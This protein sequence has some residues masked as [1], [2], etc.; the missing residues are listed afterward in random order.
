MFSVKQVATKKG[1]LQYRHEHFTGLQCRISPDRLKRQIDQV[2][3]VPPVPEGCPFCRDL[4]FSVTP[5]FPDGNRIIRGESVTFPN[6]YPFGEG[7]VVTVLTRDH[8]VK[9]FSRQQIVDGLFS[10]IEAL[11][12][13]D[14]FA[15]INWNYLPSSGA[16][17]VHPHMQGL[18][19][20]RPSRIVE[21]YLLA[22]K[23]YRRKHNRNY[24]LSLQEEEKVSERYLFGDEITWF[25]HAVP[26]GEREVRGI[27]PI[28]TL[29]DMEC[30]VDPMA[31]GILEIL[32]LYRKLGTS[33]FNMS[34][35]FD[36]AG[37]DHDFHAFCAMISRINPNPSST[38]DSAFM[39]RLH[40]EPIIMTLP[41]DLG[42]FYKKEKN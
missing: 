38:S 36:K 16:S 42:K 4:V 31:R 23:Q 40:L 11:R 17:L 14:G 13:Y 20:Y 18:A 22:G 3:Y 25:A 28:S 41:E 35:F 29:D 34:I 32:D 26:L 12:K 9:I 27:L 30:Y 39:E 37:S 8:N 5:P 33:A 19:D 24:W 1:I 15:S 7:H 21:G 10:Q 6:L 2:A